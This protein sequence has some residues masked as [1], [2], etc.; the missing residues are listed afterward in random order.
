MF[1]AI[2]LL[3][4][5]ISLMADPTPQVSLAGPNTT[6]DESSVVPLMLA[7]TATGASTPE[8]NPVPLI[9]VPAPKP[10]SSAKFSFA[11]TAAM[12]PAFS[13]FESVRS[14]PFRS[15]DNRNKKKIWYGLIVAGHAGA[16]LDAWSTRRALSGHYGTE[17]DPIMRP[18]AHSNSLYLVTQVSPTV[19][20]F[21]G[22]R[23]M[24][25]S[26][27]WVRR[28]W[29]VPQAAGTAISFGAG[30]HNISIVP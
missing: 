13:P 22:R 29:W 19:L 17:G 30:A 10:V 6:I 12:K 26:H 5:P 14:D 23:A 24:S 27:P 11:R 3:L 8:A 15:S 2:L 1:F 9:S 20:D 16:A 25:N 21:I 18:F 4:N 28:L 7:S